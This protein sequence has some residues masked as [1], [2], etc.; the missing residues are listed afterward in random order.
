MLFDTHAHLFW[1][2][3]QEDLED[4]LDR[5]REAGVE[6]ILNLGTDPDTSR[7]CVE[8]AEHSPLC[9]AAVG[10]HPNDAG[11]F[12]ADPRGAG[13]A[14]RNL[15]DHP[16][17]IA[18]GESGLDFYRDRSPAEAQYESLRFHFELARETGKPL[19]LHNREAGDELRETL[20][21]MDEGVTAVLHSFVG[22]TAFGRWATDRGHYL[23]LGGIFTFRTSGLPGMV[24]AWDLDR[25]LVETDSPFL[26][27]VPHRGKR[28]EP[29][30]V[31]DTARAVAEALEIP[32]E[33][34]ARRTT[35][36]AHRLFRT[37]P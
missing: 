23:G 12:A 4:V 7:A 25:L 5:A 19:V 11:G 15:V 3:F 18:I 20:E 37:G 30:F 16:R 33:E 13:D 21:E 1:E 36:N 10:W 32:F 2:D 28:N 31:A 26:A 6:G 22:D 8:L 27:P 29:A 9:W 17:V 34:L 14:I 35:A 24:H